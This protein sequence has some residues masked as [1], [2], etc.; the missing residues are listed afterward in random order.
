MDGAQA[1]GRGLSNGMID[2]TWM[3]GMAG[4]T[5]QLER[6]V[7]SS[8]YVEWEVGGD[9]ETSENSFQVWFK[10]MKKQRYSH[11]VILLKER[12]H[13]QFHRFTAVPFRTWNSFLFISTW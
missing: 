7:V 9:A 11:E 2:M 10:V 13:P 8:V 3:K 1:E 12:L 4:C 6:R 5:V